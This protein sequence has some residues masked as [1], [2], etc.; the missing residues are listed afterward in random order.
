MVKIDPEVKTYGASLSDSLLSGLSSGALGKLGGQ[1]SLSDAFEL[2][3]A[4]QPKEEKFDPAMAALLYF[5]EMGKNASKPGATLLGSA[6]GAFTSPAAYL[7]QQRKD[8]KD[9]KSKLAPLAVSIAQS[10]DKKPKSPIIQLFEDLDSLT[11][12][13]PEHDAVLNQIQSENFNKPIFEAE[14]KIQAS[15]DVATRSIQESR[16]SYAKMVSSRETKA[17]VGDL[18]MIFGFMKMLDPG[19]VVRESEFSAAQDTAGLMQKLEVQVEKIQKGALLTDKQRTAFLE[20]SKKFMDSG[21]ERFIQ[22]RRD[23][24]LQADYHNLN[25]INI[26][27]FEAAHPAWYINEQAYKDAEKA[28]MT[29][30]ELWLFMS[31]EERDLWVKDNGGS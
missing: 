30:N 11:P 27:G 5:T 6:S 17:G 26:F 29:I 10:L 19:S 31:E 9:R 8:E 12:G 15:F 20:L 13:T 7:M 16:Q 21:E 25:P 24:G 23:K 2:A 14:N 1:S 3:K 28:G 22:I 4:L 18:A